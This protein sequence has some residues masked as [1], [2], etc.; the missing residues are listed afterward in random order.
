MMLRGNSRIKSVTLA[1]CI[2]FSSQVF[3]LETITL[4]QSQTRTHPLNASHQISGAY[5]MQSYF[6]VVNDK[7]PMIYQLSWAEDSVTKQKKTVLNPYRNLEKL[8]GY[9][10]Y[11]SSIKGSKK[12]DLEGVT[13]CSSNG[14]L[15]YLVNEITG[16]ILKADSKNLSKLDINYEDFPDFRYDVGNDGFMGVTADCANQKLYVAKQKNPNIVFVVDLNAKRVV[17]SFDLST[18]S[19]AEDDIS[20]LFFKDNKLYVLQ[21]NVTSIAVVNPNKT[22]NFIEKRYDYSVM[23]SFA[24]TGDDGIAEGIVVQNG[25]AFL[26][27]DQKKSDTAYSKSK[28]VIIELKI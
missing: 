10:S 23:S 25:S 6:F 12:F 26:F 28:D 20:D 22:S 4:D 15:F 1:L 19:D 17:N 14:L 13:S 7:D 18:G 8:Y 9:Y 24:K 3:A 16:D 11:A 2:L 21:K 27:L 5:G